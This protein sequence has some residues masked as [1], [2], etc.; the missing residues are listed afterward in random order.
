VSVPVSTSA[1]SQPSTVTITAAA[2]ATTKAIDIPIYP[3]LL[4]S[5]TASGTVKGGMATKLTLGLMTS[6][7]LGGAM[8]SLSSSC[9]TIVLP[10]T[11]TVPQGT[12]YLNVAANT[13]AVSADEHCTVSAASAYNTI[14][15]VITLTP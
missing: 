3:V 8:V 15:T 10:A 4:R 1:V 13:V 6:A 11:A 2:K 12:A 7:P 9:T 14:S 5:L